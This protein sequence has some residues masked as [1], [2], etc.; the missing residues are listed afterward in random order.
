MY[1]G[2]AMADLDRLIALG[3]DRQAREQQ[4]A[5][6]AARE[7]EAEAQRVRSAEDRAA[8]QLR[9]FTVVASLS[10]ASTLCF[11]TLLLAWVPLL[12]AV[13]F[14]GV[15]WIVCGALLLTSLASFL[16]VLHRRRELLRITAAL[17]FPVVDLGLGLN[18]GR[19]YPSCRLTVEFVGPAPASAP[20]EQAFAALR[21]VRPLQRVT[22]EEREGQKVLVLLVESSEG[23]KFDGHRR[24]L[25]RWWRD[26]ARSVLPALHAAHPIARLT[27]P[28]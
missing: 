8:L 19:S 16:W 12:L 11:I 3:R 27:F 10:R 5:A 24:W 9:T 23:S 1:R 2:L 22:V 7:A 15:M 26:A 21:G 20:V 14:G 13:G 18:W 17:P 4:L 25:V 28:S 6:A